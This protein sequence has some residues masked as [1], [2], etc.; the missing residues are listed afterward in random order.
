[1][2]QTQLKQKIA[3][4]FSKLPKEAQTAFSSMLWMETLKGIISKYNLNPKEAE[5]LGTETTLALLGIISLEEYQNNLERELVVDE[6]TKEKIIKEIDD[7]ILKT[8]KEQ[9][10]V[11]FETNAEALL[12]ES[13]NKPLVFDPRFISMPQN[14][15][16]AIARSSWKEILF[17]IAQ[18]YKLTV[19]QTGILEE[20]TAKVMLNAIHP[21]N[22]EKEI[23]SKITIQKEEIPLLVGEVNQEILLKIRELLKER[24]DIIKKDDKKEVD[25][26]PLPPY[27]K[28]KI[29]IPEPIKQ[30]I[31]PNT[32]PPVIQKIE[33]PQ[34]AVAA[35]EI[36]NMALN[37]QKESDPLASKNNPSS[38]SSDPYREAF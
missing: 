7:T 30:P 13:R 6:E 5:T 16:E 32:I 3:E 27:S 2:D 38:V 15:Q 33:V 22:Y 29:N 8:I 23:T 9:L 26:I 21:N 11:A 14:V 20:I 31:V 18:K 12:N 34:K 4:Y 25:E 37:Y 35:G 17:G 28:V 19:E 10:V 1:M 24:W 36:N